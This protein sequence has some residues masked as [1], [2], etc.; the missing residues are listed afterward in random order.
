MVTKKDTTQKYITT[1]CSNCESVYSVDFNDGDVTEE[2]PLFCPFCGE[3]LENDD[4]LDDDY[5]DEE[6]ETSDDR[7]F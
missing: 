4:D 1:D 6:Q 7:R 3:S 2:I 5:D